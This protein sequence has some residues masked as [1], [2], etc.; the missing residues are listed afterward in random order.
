MYRSETE[1]TYGSMESCRNPGMWNLEF[2][3]DPTFA[4]HFG[5]NFR[6]YIRMSEDIAIPELQV[7]AFRDFCKTEDYLGI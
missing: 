6:Q 3:Q 4:E 7:S 2:Q 1:L 5:H